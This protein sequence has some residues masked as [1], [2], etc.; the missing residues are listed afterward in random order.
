MCETWSLIIRE[1]QIFEYRVLRRIFEPKRNEVA[2]GSRNVH[3]EELHYLYSSPNIVNRD[4]VQK[5][6]IG[7]TCSKHDCESACI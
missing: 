3:N 2:G 1:E 6:E 5:N 7:R 4:E